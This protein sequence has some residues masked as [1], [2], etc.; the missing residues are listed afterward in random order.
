MPLV[1][2]AA[3]WV[4]DEVGRRGHGRADVS[5]V[6]RLGTVYEGLAAISISGA[7]GLSTTPANWLSQFKGFLRLPLPF[8]FADPRSPYEWIAS[9]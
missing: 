9:V 8:V 4:C 3:A 6:S 7:P 2:A 5:L 1:T